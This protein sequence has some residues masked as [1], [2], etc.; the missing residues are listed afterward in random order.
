MPRAVRG[1]HHSYQR[2]DND[3]KIAIQ[4][5]ADYYFTQT[6]APLAYL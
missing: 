6:E 5:V 1:E 3:E 2:Y 4:V